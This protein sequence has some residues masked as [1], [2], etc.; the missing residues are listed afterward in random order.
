MLGQRGPWER[1]SDLKDR[2]ARQKGLVPWWI[3]IGVSRFGGDSV[4][5]HWGVS[6]FSG[7]SSRLEGTPP[8]YNGMGLLILGQHYSPVT[9]VHFSSHREFK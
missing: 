8:P 9:M 7:D 3:L 6:P 2:R 1:C 4:D 5:F